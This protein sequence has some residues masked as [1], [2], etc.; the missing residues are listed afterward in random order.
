MSSQHTREQQNEGSQVFPLPPKT[1]DILYKTRNV[2]STCLH[3]Q[4]F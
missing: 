4:V 1:E 3:E 2:C